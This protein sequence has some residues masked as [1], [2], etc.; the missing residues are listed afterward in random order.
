MQFLY[1]T[2]NFS[3]TDDQIFVQEFNATLKTVK[4]KFTIGQFKPPFGME[5]FEPD[6]KMPM[7]DRSQASDRLIPNG[8]VGDSF[9]RDL[10]VQWQTSPTNGFNYTVGIFDGNGANEHF[11]GSGPLVAGR[12]IYEWRKA[13]KLFHAEAAVS[14]RRDHNIDFLAQ[15]PGAPKGYADFA[16]QDVRQD[17]ALDYDWAGN[18]LWGEL[19]VS[20][21]HSDKAGVPDVN[22]N[23]FYVQLAR[24][25]SKRWQGAVRYEEL[26]TD[27]P[28]GN[29]Q[30]WTTVGTTYRIHSDYE[31]IQVNYVFKNESPNEVANN[32]LIVQYQRFLW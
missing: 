30:Q 2:G 9:T 7:V 21:Y 17:L 5:R 3:S 27:L 28:A 10:G 1:K 25:F 8:S 24:N 32:A 6:W 11:R 18:S 26:N 31:K 12:G 20:R 4:G 29:S 23:G 13:G 22:A 14:W 16:G 19:I 15:F